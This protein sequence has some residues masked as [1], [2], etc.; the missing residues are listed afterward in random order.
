MPQHQSSREQHE[1]S[2]NLLC[3]GLGASPGEISGKV[4]I[5]NDLEE[6]DQVTEQDIIV[7]EMTMPEMVP[8]MKRASGIVTNQGGITCHAAIVSRELGVPAIVGTGDAT[9]E[10]ED[11]QTVEID[12]D[13][14]TIKKAEAS[15]VLSSSSETDDTSQ[16]SNSSESTSSSTATTDPAVPTTTATDVFVNVSIPEAAERAAATDAD[17]V[18]LLR[19]EHI[20]LSLQKTPAK[21]VED[22]GADEFVDQVAQEVERVA[23]AFYPREVRARTM[24]APTDELA[25][26][27][28][29][30]AEP[31]E[32]NPM[33]GWRG[34][35]RSL[36]ET[37]LTKL[38]LR[39]FKQVRDNGYD[40]LYV[41]FP[42]P[43]DPEEVVEARELM[44]EVGIN[45]DETKWGAMIETPASVRQIDEIIDTG[46]DFAALGTNDLI[47]YILAVD[48]N[49]GNVADVFD[50]MHPA[51]LEAMSEVIEACNE[52]DVHTTITGQAGSRP[53]MARFLVNEGISSVS[54]NIDAVDTVREVIGRAEQ[55]LILDE[56]RA[57]RLD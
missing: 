10:L 18:G 49:N 51:V 1:D 56:V 45:P 21:Y 2:D 16:T 40:N 43:N 52:N 20:L 41:M 24:D 36:D 57:E 29:G 23:E 34:I 12:G 37:S 25:E 47:Q 8:A 28:G 17:G 11:G 27:E 44:R 19:V 38:E 30:E 3:Q 13:R 31:H 33:L 15:D 6:T 7:T 48:R 32:H 53:E 50:E 39:A 55:K 22:H 5:V 42:L 14:G 54:A 35:R 4:T 26:L 9:T 46:I